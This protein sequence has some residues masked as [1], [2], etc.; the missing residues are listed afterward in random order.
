MLEISSFQNPSLSEMGATIFFAIAIIHTFLCSQFQKLAKRYPE[1]SIGE[2]IFHLLGEVEVVFGLWAGLF[3]LSSMLFIDFKET[4]FYLENRNFTEPLFVFVIMATCASKPILELSGNLIRTCG[5]ALPINKSLG[6]YIA[7]LIIGPV[8]GSFITEPA[9]M[10]VTALVL[11]RNFY[12][13]NIS[14]DL[15][16]ATIGLLFVNISIGGTLTPYAAPPVL[17]VAAKWNWD[18]QFMLTNFGWKSLVAIT[19]STVLIAFRFRREI[20]RIDT[21]VPTSKSKNTSL[22]LWVTF[23]HLLILTLIVFSA[24]HPT[25]FVGLF[26][27]FLGIATVTKEYQ[28]ELKIKEALLVSF[29]LGGLVILGGLQSWWIEP[30]LTNLSALP[31]FLGSMTLT[32]FTDN[33][34]ITYLG[35]QI[36]YLSDASKYALVAGSVAGGGLTVIANAPNPAG[37]STLNPAFGPHGISPIKLFL[38]ACLPT[39]IAGLCLWVF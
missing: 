6:F 11:F 37:Y 22:P 4:L 5:Q 13:N 33:A 30:V 32:A 35:S 8:L 26:L 21:Q 23:L 20:S 7:I 1:G 36:P 12:S 34:A 27:F 39:F 25:L 18:L 2:N 16:Y 9:A 29:F 14:T 19:L 38:S 24:H 10:T 3:I 28:N 17:M 31:L 15:K